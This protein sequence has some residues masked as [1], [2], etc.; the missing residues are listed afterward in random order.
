MRTPA[1]TAETKGFIGERYDDDSGL[2]FTGAR[3]YDPKL[4]MF[5]QPDW[6]EV[7]QPGVGTNRYS[8][9][10]ND[11]INL[12]DPNGN[13]VNTQCGDSGPPDDGLRDE[14]QIEEYYSLANRAARNGID[15]TTEYD[16]S[17][18]LNVV[19]DLS[20]V[21]GTIDAANAAMAGDVSGVA[22]GALEIALGKVKVFKGLVKKFIGDEWGSVP[23]PNSTK[24]QG[25]STKAPDDGTIYVDS[26]GNAIPT[27]KGG[28]ITGSP[29]GKFIQARD[30]TGAP[31]GVRIDG[32]HSPRT[33]SD[34]R[35]LGP[36]GHVPGL[37][38][39]D[40]TPW[41]PIR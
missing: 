14:D 23:G 35:A 8:Y 17:D 29:D 38:N 30:A 28:R 9:S 26:K 21:N 4:A 2:Q 7:T 36:H 39:P 6:F 41:L 15:V 10:F 33:H 3:Y 22:T 25:I 12:S 24:G 1:H 32:A 18:V 40:G 19:G 34:P 31:T 5:I 20:G 11:P 37:T 13:C 27:P 16:P